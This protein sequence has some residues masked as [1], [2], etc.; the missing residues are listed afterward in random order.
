MSSTATSGGNTPMWHIATCGGDSVGLWSFQ[1]SA[2]AT[3]LLSASPSAD[4]SQI[5]YIIQPP[6]APNKT[7]QFHKKGSS[8]NA[9]QWNHNSE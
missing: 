7:C 4:N 8:I 5:P 9:I 3:T 1:S 2:P 6:N